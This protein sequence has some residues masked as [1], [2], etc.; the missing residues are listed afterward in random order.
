[1]STTLSRRTVL[2]LAGAA[3]LAL[4]GLDVTHARQSTAMTRPRQWRVT[5][6]TAPS[7][8]CFDTA[9]R[10]FM[11]ARNISC[12]GLAVTRNGR[13][14]LAR[15]YT[16]SSDSNLLVQPQTLFR[17][18]S[19]TKPFTAAATMRLVQDG[20]LRLDQR[21]TDLITLTPPPGE[22]ADPRLADITVLRLLQHLG[23]WDSSVSGDP[24]FADAI[25]A[26]FLGIGLPIQIPHI[27]TAATSLT[28]DHAPGTAYIYSNYG[29]CL[30]GRIIEA[31][32]HQPY[33][34]FVQQQVLAPLGIRH[35]HVGRSLLAFRDP[36]EVPYVSQ[37]SDPTVF[38]NSGTLVPE[39]YGSFN[40]ENLD[41]VGAWVGSPVELAHF[42]ATFD[43]PNTSPILTPASIAQTFAV[44]E[45][46]PQPDGAYYGCGW[47][48]RPTSNG[49]ITWHTGSLPGTHTMVLRR[50]DGVNWA[51]LF[52]QRDDPSGSSYDDIGPLLDQTASSVS[53]WPSYDLFRTYFPES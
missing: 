2:K 10:G 47:G 37:F 27:I 17:I 45:I 7:L 14:M 46:G 1:M 23:G 16:W 3:G 13:L 22:T 51:V 50:D 44:P 38:D 28:L 26:E 31:V 36:N 25:I 40:L 15:G 9:L 33:Q 35:M 39:P 42:A 24:M 43:N 52:N 6:Q 48:V 4:T 11:Q 32:S 8:V 12:G 41:S 29:Y 5:G 18:A 21:L 20:R 49:R 30:L 53:F 34:T 19:I